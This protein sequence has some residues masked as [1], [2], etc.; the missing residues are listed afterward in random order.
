MS[1]NRL[2]VAKK[3]SFIGSNKFLS[4]IKRKY[5]V[6][7]AG[8]SGTLDP[9]ACGVLIIAF[10][11][12]TKLFRFLKKSPKRYRAVLWLGVSSPTLDIEKVDKIE[13]IAPFK[14]DHIVDVISSFTGTF[15]YYPPKFSAK[16]VD[17]K[18]AYDLAREGKRVELS[19]ISSTIYS[20]KVINY[21]HPFVTFE[22]TVSEGTY[23]RS[24]AEA[25]SEKLGYSG[26]L[27]YLERLNEGLFIYNNEEPLNP[28]EYLQPP[29][30]RYLGD[31]NDL[32]MGK[33]LSI[34]KFEISKPG[35]YTVVFDKYFAIIEIKDTVYYL[36][37]KV[38]LC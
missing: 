18:R 2:F 17:G 27:S 38:K 10:G 8:F 23:I 3:P 5:G 19:Q 9:F 28:L 24:L 4:Q 1:S 20:I 6:K 12:Y 32:L 21:S 37:N 26:T 33:K 25:I 22:A 15:R 29:L 14:K 36:L 7:K 13:N 16:K 35:V 30:N 34:S 11:Q 31:P